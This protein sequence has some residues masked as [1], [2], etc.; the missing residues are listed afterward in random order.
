MT[1]AENLL[2]IS[3]Y[4]Y[5]ILVS[6][7][8]YMIWGIKKNKLTIRNYLKGCL[9][10]V[11]SFILSLVAIYVVPY[12]KQDAL[13]PIVVSFF[14]PILYSLLLLWG[15]YDASKRSDKKNKGML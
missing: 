15:L 13:L 6:C 11:P 5:S 10:L 2:V 4:A 12:E 14:I 7:V 9:C 1:I 3:P 8:V